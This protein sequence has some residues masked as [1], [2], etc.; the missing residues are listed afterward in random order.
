MKPETKKTVSAVV[1]AIIGAYIVTYLVDAVKI[2]EVGEGILIGV[3]I[4]VKKFV[5]KVGSGLGEG[6]IILGGALLT[7]SLLSRF[8]G[9]TLK[10]FK[11]PSILM[12]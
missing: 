4:G 12:T 1:G 6:M 9:G 7:M 8:L 11:V 2:P 10:M 3:G 5:P